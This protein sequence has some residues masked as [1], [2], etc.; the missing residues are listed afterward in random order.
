MSETNHHT[1]KFSTENV[2]PIE[3]EKTQILIN[4]P[5]NLGLS[6]LELSKMLMYKFFFDYVNP[7]YGER[8]NLFCIDSNSFIKI[9]DI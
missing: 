5:V 1:G 2:L 4:K 6:I 9:D 3:N 8:A 7:K